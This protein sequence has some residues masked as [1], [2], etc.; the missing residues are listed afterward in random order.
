MSDT[1]DDADLISLDEERSLNK[2]AI[3]LS[4]DD[5]IS[6]NSSTDIDSSEPSKNVDKILEEVP[7]YYKAKVESYHTWEIEDITQLVGDEKVFGPK[8]KVGDDFVFNPLITTGRRDNY[9]TFSVYL[10]GAPVDSKLS[11]SGDWHCCAQFALDIWNPDDPSENKRNSTHFRY[12]PRVGDWGFINLLDGRLRLDSEL[13]NHKRLNITSYVRIIDDFTGV[14]WHDFI[15]YDSKKSTGYV[16]INN[17]GATCYLNSLLQSYYFTKKFR[18]KV[19]QIPTQDEIK[20]NLDSF[21]EYLEQPKSVS[22]ALQRIFY[23]LQ[24]SDKPIDTMELTDSFGWTSADAFTQHDVQE[25]NRILMDKLES[26]MKHTDIEGCLNDIFVG[27]MKSFIRCVNVDYESSRTEDFWDI[28]LN[29]KGLKNIKQSFENYIEMELL[30]GENKYDA[31][32]YGLQAAQKGVV[33]ENFPPVLHLQLKR[34]EYNFEYDQLMKV[35]DRYEFFNSIDLKPY[36][37]KNAE[38]YNEDWE[39]ELHCVLVHQGDV[40]MGHYY[41]MIKPNEEDKWFRFDDDK[42]WR[43]TPDEVFEGSFGADEDP[44][45]L[46]GMT[47]DEQQDFQLRRHTSAYMLVYIRKSKVAEILSEVEHKDI[48][49]HIPKQIKYEREQ[50]A[51]IEKEQEEMHLYANFKVFYHKAFTKYQGFDLGPDDEDQQNYCE[52]LYDEESYPLSFRLLKTNSFSKVFDTVIAKLNLTVDPKFLRF[53]INFRRKNYALRPGKSIYFNYNDAVSQRVTIESVI[54]DYQIPKNSHHNSGL[55]ESVHISL[56]LE[57][58]S[59]DLGF[60]SNSIYDMKKNGKLSSK[61]FNENITE[62]Y[63]KMSQMALQHYN[64]KLE[65]TSEDE[66]EIIDDNSEHLEHDHDQENCSKYLI[67]LKFFDLPKQKI[68][69]LC[70]VMAKMDKPVQS[71][72]PFINNIM[73]FPMNTQLEYYEELGSDQIVHIQSG[74]TFYKSELDNGDIICFTKASWGDIKSEAEYLTVPDMYS[75][76]ANRVHFKVS[77]LQKVDE[78]EEDYI[79]HRSEENKEVEHASKSFEMWFSTALGYKAFAKKIGERLELDPEYLRLFIVGRPNQ[80]FP[81]KSTTP[82]KRLLARIPKSQTLDICYEVLSV[83]LSDFEHMILCTVF[84]VGQGICREQKHEFF[85]PKF[86]TVIDLIDRLQS[87]VH[88]KPE[89]EDSLVVWTMDR[90]HRLKSICESDMKI[91]ESPEFIVGYYPTYREVL[92]TKP[93]NIKLIPGFQ[94]FGQIQNSHSLPFIF[95]LVQ[96]EKLEDTKVRIHKLLGISEKEF[97]NVRIA[98]TDLNAVDYMDSSERDSVELFKLAENTPFYLAIEHPDR[99][100][101]RA[102]AYEPSLYIKG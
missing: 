87:K 18:K 23:N 96:G 90:K 36:M 67:F 71:L 5:A 16:G 89:E 27:K 98:V 46:K 35:N 33:F 24:T 76:L 21:R 11:A 75:Y 17:Q 62:N 94:F 4:S 39:Y 19:Y 42:V 81:L 58:A 1:I 53:W 20:F 49:E 79:V 72:T 44:D 86:S 10:A 57:D 85:L 15:D 32:G 3:D 2:D 82:L 7:S 34:F 68:Y 14:L 26:R 28:Q 93:K 97:E 45:T 77:S 31:A 12:N 64:P 48:P 52:D 47:R 92:R 25:M 6:S 29:V 50:L 51:K 40:S 70:H 101:R 91:E 74:S 95:D 80:T 38:H 41:A 55:E 84:W 65:L 43:V 54:E 100:L 60:V 78:D 59:V 37:D 63:E 8:F 13:I 73:N 66:Y 69:G 88:F 102:S 30:D 56:Y 99:N 83:T 61:E 22:L 9:L